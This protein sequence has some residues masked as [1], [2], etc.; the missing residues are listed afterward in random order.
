MVL[1]FRTTF[2]VNANHK[3][4]ESTRQGPPPDHREA[5][6]D[7]KPTTARMLRQHATNSTTGCIKRQLVGLQ[8][9][10]RKTQTQTAPHNTHALSHNGRWARHAPRTQRLA[11][12]ETTLVVEPKTR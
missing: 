9:A 4:Q 5:Q 3:S 1:D 12:R 6:G 7:S 8:G 10:P 11:T 2:A